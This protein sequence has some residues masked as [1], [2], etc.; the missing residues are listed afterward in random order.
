M[1]DVVIDIPDLL[2]STP[3]EI[4]LESILKKK[5][6][7]TAT[8]LAEH[9]K[10]AR[11]TMGDKLRKWEKEGY[12]TSKMLPVKRGEICH[13]SRVYFPKIDIRS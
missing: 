1:K 4:I 10:C 11:R 3:D 2:L 8:T 12:L 9:L 7:V 13:I 5:K 6:G